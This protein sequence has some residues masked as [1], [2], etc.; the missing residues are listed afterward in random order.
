MYVTIKT[1]MSV[2]IEGLADFKRFNIVSQV[3]GKNIDQVKQALAGLASV[4]NDNKVWVSADAFI[5]RIPTAKDEAWLANFHSMIESSR[6]Y[7]YIRDN[8]LAI[9]AHI[10]WQDPV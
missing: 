6:K 8:P 3:P 2:A 4:E 7:G 5:N 1:D 10:E 9:A